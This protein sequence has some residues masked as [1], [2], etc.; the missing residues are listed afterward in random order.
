[1]NSTEAGTETN[2]SE[3]EQKNASS[4]ITRSLDSPPNVTLRRA[5]Q[6]EK[7]R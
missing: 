1:M 2:F 6:E 3:R 5:E 4:S 7:Q